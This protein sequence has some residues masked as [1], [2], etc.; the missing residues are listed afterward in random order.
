M[1]KGFMFCAFRP[2]VLLRWV[3]CAVV[4][5]CAVSG[6]SPEHYKAD[7]D[8]EVYK[9]IDSKW[10]DSFGQKAN[11]IISDIPPSPN[12]AQ[13]EL[14]VSSTVISLAQAVATATANN[15]N[16]QDQ[17]ETL[18][19]IAL[20]L[21]LT[22]YQ[23]VPQWFGTIDGEYFKEGSEEDLRVATSGGFE[24]MR[25]LANGVIF[26][27]GLA[28]D[29]V[30][31][32]TGDSRTTLGSVLSA[33][34]A[35][36]L[37]GNGSGKIDQENLTQAERE[38]LYQ[39]RSFNRFR[40]IF[41]VSI[42]S[43]Y[44]D[45]LQRRDRVINEEN[46]Y[47]RVA[48]SKRRLEMEAEAGRRSAIDVDEAGQDVLRAEASYVAAQQNYEQQL[49]RFKIRL[50]LPTDADVILDQNELNA[51]EVIGISEPG[52]ALDEAMETALLGRLD[53]ANSMDRIDDALRKVILAADGLGPQ[54][55]LI[56]DINVDSKEKTDLTRLQFHEGRYSVGLETDLPLDRKAQRNAYRESLIAL[57]QQ[58]REYENDVDEIKFQVRQAYRKL[59]EKA[60]SYRI[61]KDSLNLAR[62]RV[63]NNEL[64]LDAGRGTVRIL[65]QSQDAL[66]QAQNDV[67]A[68]LVDHLDAKLSFFRDV[69]I[70]QVRP[71]GMWEITSQKR[72]SKN[73]S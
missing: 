34:L 9:I 3:V 58:Q 15:R 40:K 62:R 6:C 21:T 8:K 30:R 10:H 7:A 27:T 48:E 2:M 72:E 37:L 52:Y 46:N 53:L 44:Y 73:E 59:K 32:L 65:L 14:N 38:V 24:H 1:E 20:D 12:N 66:V 17:K 33:S 5:I 57:E 69:S 25:L 49:D 64:L 39:I 56:G 43:D 31:F 36:P 28:I 54:L 35:A 45:V 18:Y 23:Y 4:A 19:L 51:L 70:L 11:Y 16:Y 50:S 13:N 42:I 61:Q 67:T 68:A 41:V 47:K 29:W 55:N 26:T 60:E 63:E 22:R 71:D